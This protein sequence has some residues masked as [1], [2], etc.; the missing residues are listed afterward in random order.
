ME[1]I[2]NWLLFFSAPISKSYV[3][4]VRL[5]STATIIIEQGRWPM[6]NGQITLQHFNVF[7]S[8]RPNQTTTRHDAVG[9]FWMT[10][11]EIVK[12][13]RKLKMNDYIHTYATVVRCLTTHTTSQFRGRKKI[14]WEIPIKWQLW[15]SNRN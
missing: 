12:L 3:P 11:C 6:T 14:T 10:D 15:W 8:K 4:D 1:K 13:V 2:T 9:G 5:F 7:W